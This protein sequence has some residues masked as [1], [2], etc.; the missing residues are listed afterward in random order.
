[1]LLA[2]AAADR[3]REAATDVL[4]RLVP[5]PEHPP[6]AVAA[7]M[8]AARRARQGI[9]IRLVLGLGTRGMGMIACLW[10]W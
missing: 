7:V 1:M 10:S 8:T 9:M 2:P 4:M 6:A 3:A 5:R